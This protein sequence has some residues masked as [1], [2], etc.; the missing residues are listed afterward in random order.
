MGSQIEERPGGEHHNQP[1]QQPRRGAAD[2]VGAHFSQQLSSRNHQPLIDAITK[3]LA[4]AGIPTVSRSKK[5]GGLQGCPDTLL[6]RQK[7]LQIR[8]S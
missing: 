4:S 8:E 5:N 2:R 7:D 6:A 3:A 1:E